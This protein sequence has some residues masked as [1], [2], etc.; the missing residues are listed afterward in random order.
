[1]LLKYQKN[2]KR[3][4][5]TFSAAAYLERERERERER[6]ERDMRERDHRERFVLFIPC[7]L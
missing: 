3:Y 5:L 4:Q 1:M 7:E 2:N 6:E